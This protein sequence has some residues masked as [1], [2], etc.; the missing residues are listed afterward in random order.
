MYIVLIFYQHKL[1]KKWSWLTIAIIDLI[2]LPC[3]VYVFSL[4]EMK[5]NGLKQLLTLKHVTL[6]LLTI[7]LRLFIN[8]TYYKLNMK[9]WTRKNLKNSKILLPN[10]RNN[11]KSTTNLEILKT[12]KHE[13]FR[14]NW[15]K[16]DPKSRWWIWKKTMKLILLQLIKK[17]YNWR[18]KN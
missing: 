11:R 12:M 1:W 4:K 16:S 5:K 6:E 9:N 15:K 18:L 17:N 2:H 14:I 3:Q 8:M 13:W 7:L 10:F